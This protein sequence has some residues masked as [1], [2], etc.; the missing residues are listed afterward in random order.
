MKNA[1]LSSLLL[2]SVVA[3]GQTAKV[4]IVGDSWAQQQYSDGIH[5]AV[6]D[7]N[8]YP[9]ISILDNADAAAV[10][11]DGTTAEDWVDPVELQKI[12]DALVN[13]PSVDTVQLTLGGNDFLN[14]WHTDMTLMETDALKAGIVADLQV[15][16]DA[17]LAVDSQI[18]II[19]SFYDYPNF[20][21]TTSG[22]FG[23]TCATLH[24]GML[25]PTPSEINNMALEFTDAFVEISNQNIKVFHVP[26]WGRMQ[27]AYGSSDGSFGPGDIPLPGYTELTSPLVAM[28][29]HF[30]F[31]KDCFHLEPAG[32]DILVQALFED[33]FLYRFDT[34]YKSHFE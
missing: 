34:V 24:N 33:Y 8:G 23:E 12:T 32:Y 9:D 19:M 1:L 29:T 28:R 16:V 21:E 10:A 17:I 11:I 3:F 26:H 4:L 20:E 13:N 31:V 14:N 5:D 6:F 22:F 25:N 30:G 18:E 15:I 7:V 27:N 2:W